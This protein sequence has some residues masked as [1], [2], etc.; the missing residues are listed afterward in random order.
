MASYLDFNLSSAFD[1]DDRLRQHCFPFA[2]KARITCTSKVHS[3]GYAMHIHQRRTQHIWTLRSWRLEYDDARLGGPQIFCAQ[4]LSEFAFVCKIEVLDKF[5]NSQVSMITKCFV[6]K[7]CSSYQMCKRALV[8]PWCLHSIHVVPHS[9]LAL[10]RHDMLPF[11]VKLHSH[12]Q[13]SHE[14][15]NAFLTALQWQDAITKIGFGWNASRMKPS[16]HFRRR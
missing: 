13:V 10:A 6:L 11:W 8:T 14:R 9:V 3:P 5:R 12:K 2:I 1:P 7:D 4:L 16:N 15:M